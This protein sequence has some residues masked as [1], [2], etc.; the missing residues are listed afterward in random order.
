MKDAVTTM[1]FVATEDA[2]FPVLWDLL[3]AT[4][5]SL[6]RPPVLDRRGHRPVAGRELPRPT[7]GD[8]IVFL[9]IP[10]CHWAK[11]LTATRT[12]TPG[13]VVWVLCPGWLQRVGD[14]LYCHRGLWADRGGQLYLD[15]FA[16]PREVTYFVNLYT[17]AETYGA[18]SDGDVLEPGLACPMSSTGEIS[19]FV[20]CKLT[21]R[22]LAA[23]RGV[24]VPRCVA[25]LLRRDL[26]VPVAAETL[27]EAGCVVVALGPEARH[28]E[29]AR[30]LARVRAE[31]DA[32]LPRWPD[33][34]ARAVVKPSG[35]MHLQC[36]GVSVHERSDHASVAAAVVDLLTDA[37]PM[38]L[39]DGDAVLV[40]AFAGGR[41]HTM[42]IR[43][44]VARSGES[45]ADASV[46]T[47]VAG[48]GDSEAPISGVTT[49]PLSIGD[50]LTGYG[51]PDAA[52]ESRRVEALVRAS[53]AATL[54]GV[55]AHEPW[56]ADK[57]G[58]RTDLLGL[59]FVLALPGDTQGGEPA[60]TPVLI[61]VNNH[62]CTAVTIQAGFTAI[63]HRVAGVDAPDAGALEEYFRAIAARSQRHR[64]AGR[65]VLVVGGVNVSK[66]FVWHA[67]RESGVRVVLANDRPVGP[68]DGLGSELCGEV[69]VPRLNLDHSR[70]GDEANALAIVDDLRRRG[71]VVDGVITFWEDC[72]VVAALVAAQLGLRGNPVAAQRTAKD[73]LAT[74]RAL[75][76]APP[77]GIEI[78]PA[79]PTLLPPF[80]ELETPDDVDGA[81]ARKLRYPAVLR[82]RFGAGAVGTRVVRSRDEARAE[83]QR[84]VALIGD[85]DA[86]DSLYP[87]YGF[88]FGNGASSVLLTSFADGSEH[89]V[90]LLLFDGEL[91]DAWVTDNGPTDLPLCAETCA[92]MPSRLSAARQQQLISA[93]WL[94]CRRVGL[95]NGA[96]NVEF[97]LS[98]TGPKI[99]E[100]NGR[101]GGFY[102]PEWTRRI[103]GFDVATAC[104]Q[105]ACGIRPVG[106]VRRTPRAAIAG[107]LVFTGDGAQPDAPAGTDVVR[108]QLGD[109]DPDAE[110][111]E[112]IESVG[113]SA[114]TPDEAVARLEAGVGELYADRPAR[115]ETL[116]RYAKRLPH[117]G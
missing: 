41:V 31:L 101:L 55:T 52:A 70:T 24:P 93:A 54:A 50:A 96:A 61:E 6:R 112:A 71:I 53:A 36:V 116:R 77:F 27:D 32:H 1:P 51:V 46:V 13:S 42:R 14:R 9:E 3:H 26:A 88:R 110:Y 69:I 87:G 72:T 115:A 22:L 108:V 66:R 20:G 100:I 114:A 19:A 59:D 62:D 33:F 58:G 56:R 82:F 104:F 30:L 81:A 107:V 4:L 97:K 79:G 80:V 17:A 83:A 85:A 40:D 90:D 18:R 28:W 8:C 94:A 64:L 75:A 15:D 99:I 91:I 67:A 5:A 47:M 49:W 12:L 109:G 86:A 68:D 25:F 29:R 63:D 16:P 76:A 44:I 89:D 92:V 60:L 84:L 95:E 34:V 111:L 105:I 65:T 113:W 35:P 21:T 23:Q 48:I 10:E 43:A 78:A 37:G 2:Q 38:P 102:I 11:S 73:K 57:A 98:S 103:W 45:P 7:P 106:R 117:D 39:Q 74:S